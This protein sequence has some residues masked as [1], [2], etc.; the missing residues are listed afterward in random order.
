MGVFDEGVHKANRDDLNQPGRDKP[1]E[2]IHAAE[3]ADIAM[4]TIL[5]ISKFQNA[6]MFVQ[7]NS[8]ATREICP[9]QNKHNTA[10]FWNGISSIGLWIAEMVQIFTARRGGRRRRR[11][12]QENRKRIFERPTRPRTALTKVYLLDIPSTTLQSEYLE[13]T[14]KRLSTWRY[15]NLYFQKH[16]IQ[17][18]FIKDAIFRVL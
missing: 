2:G 10:W 7:Q 16:F 15:L 3:G 17:M 11:K 4:K 14:H 1:R 6:K 8:T 5:K 13:L 12:G 18:Y 9:K